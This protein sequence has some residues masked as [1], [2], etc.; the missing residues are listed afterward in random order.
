MANASDVKRARAGD[1]NLRGADLSGADLSGIDLTDADLIGA[2][3]KESRL[4]DADLRGASL[5]WAEM[6]L[7]VCDGAD[8]RRA[9]MVGT[10][11]SDA[12]LTD[13]KLRYANMSK[14]IL[15]RAK[16][17][18]ARM[19]DSNLNRASLVDAY[20]FRA[21][22]T[23]ANL[24]GAYLIGADL[25]EA[26]LT[27][28]DLTGADLYM[29][30]LTGAILAR[31]IMTG[32]IMT[33][34]V[35]TVDEA[36]KGKQSA[37]KRLLLGFVLNP[38]NGRVVAATLEAEENVRVVS[39]DGKTMGEGYFEREYSD[40]SSNLTGLT[41][42]HTAQGVKQQS[43]GYG[44]SLYTAI[45]LCAH[46]FYNGILSRSNT[47]KGPAVVGDGISSYHC[48]DVYS[49][50]E[51][52][53]EW[54]KS[55]NA[56]HCMT[57]RLIAKPGVHPGVTY[58]TG[59]CRVDAYYYDRA[60]QLGLVLLEATDL[61]PYDSVGNPA[62]LVGKL[63]V[64]SRASARNIVGADWGGMARECGEAET[65]ALLSA[66]AHI[67]KSQKLATKA[68]IEDAAARLSSKVSTPP[69]RVQRKCRG[70]IVKK[71]ETAKKAKT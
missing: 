68:D 8:M 6:D 36:E 21:D 15:V 22:L 1:K 39:P 42:A 20:L 55:A 14:A 27:G 16:L 28:A 38:K 30:N 18:G 69:E 43:A 66:F 61:I 11:L 2:N 67:L 35:R 50:S 12:D 47:R 60:K 37:T 26:D 13:A 65:M 41:R 29:T 44:T 19:R 10:F 49:R 23:Q 52:A 59:Y 54:W 3:L 4:I 51:D 58:D 56:K 5:S 71:F 64:P 31:A 34:A 25:T 46:L 45:N 53:R 70:G 17:K 40:L 48:E 57:K 24:R 33:G 7:A 32:A 9:V 62:S 63:K